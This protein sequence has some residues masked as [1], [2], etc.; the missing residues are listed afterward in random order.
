M[1]RVPGPHIA[2]ANPGP[3]VTE[4]QL[5][6]AVIDACRLLSYRVYH[7]F[8][9]RRSESGF[10]DIIALRERDGRRYAIELKTAKGKATPAQMDW[11]ATF[12]ACGI[13]SM[14]VRP[15]DLNGLLETLR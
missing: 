3:L 11:L 1:T 4:K 8:D 2:Q 12:A 6:H 15:D 9:S 10:P 13:P 5:Q 7:T 14:I